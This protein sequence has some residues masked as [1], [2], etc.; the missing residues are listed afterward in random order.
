[1]I[2]KHIGQN[3]KVGAEGGPPSTPSRSK[4]KALKRIHAGYINKMEHLQS[5][6]HSL[7]LGFQKPF[8]TKK[9]QTRI[10]PVTEID[11]QTTLQVTRHT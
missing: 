1:M 10:N 8:Y 3:T 2:A 4:S 11:P 7:F 5:S 6:L 9:I